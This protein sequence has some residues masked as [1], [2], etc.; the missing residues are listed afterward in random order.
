MVAILWRL[1]NKLG[2]F[3]EDKSGIPR[4]FPLQNPGIFVALMYTSFFKF[5]G[6]PFENHLDQ[7]FLFLGPDHQE[8]LA[9]LLYFIETQKGLALVCGD[10]GT[11]KT[12]LLTSFLDR[13][14]DTVQPIIIASPRVSPQDLLHYVATALAIDPAGK[15]VLELMDA[16]KNA[17]AEFRRRERQVVLI[18]DEAHLLSDEALEEIRLL[19]NLESPREKLL[20]ILLVGQYDLSHKLNRPEMQ[21]LRQRLNVNRFLPHL[22]AAGTIQY[23]DHR[24][25]Q[26]GSSFASVLAEGT[27]GP[28]YKITRGVPRLIN[29]LCD[30]ALLISLAAGRRRVNRRTIRKAAAALQTDRLCTLPSPSRRPSSR[31]WRS[32]AVLIPVG[33]GVAMVLLVAMAV[34]SGFWPGRVQ[35]LAASIV[36]AG[37]P[38]PGIKPDPRPAAIPAPPASGPK[39]EPMIPPETKSTPPAPAPG[40]PAGASPATAAL[41]DDPGIGRV[42]TQAGETLSRIAARHY[43]GDKKWGLV[44]IM[45][46]NPGVKNEDSL[47]AGEELYLPKLNPHNRTIQLNDKLF[48]VLYGRYTS[49][50]SAAKIA[51]W[52]KNRKINFLIRESK[53]GGNPVQ[54]IFLGGYPTEAEVA[55]VRQSLITKKN[56][57]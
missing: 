22:T 29:Q 3:T 37:Q 11:G 21:P 16:V 12:M 51:S 48:Y 35:Q 50:A 46:Q 8:V 57:P 41:P 45:L 4:L 20:Q 34:T 23:I 2:V 26:V 1:T 10:A 19:S 42:V 54:R 39:P 32:P 28:I 40:Q 17:L 5:S 55:Q 24:L 36:S 49:A 33:A 9:A 30:N 47:I 52:L 44:A 15:N 14:P 18:I 6:S 7:R 25:Q 27:R 56:V 31:R 53:S 43:P 13:L 38:A